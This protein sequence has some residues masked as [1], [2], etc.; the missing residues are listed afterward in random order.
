MNDDRAD[1]GRPTPC[2]RHGPRRR[3]RY[4]R[5]GRPRP[6]RALPRCRD[7]YDRLG[8]VCEACCDYRQTA[9]YYR[10]AINVIRNC[11]PTT[12]IPS[13]RSPSSKGSSTGSNRRRTTPPTE[14]PAG[15]NPAPASPGARRRQARSLLDPPCAPAPSRAGRRREMVRQSHQGMIRNNDPMDLP[16]SVRDTNRQ[17]SNSVIR[18]P[19]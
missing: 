9:D 10:K 2:G 6:A 4:R 7:G 16:R 3:S 15:P 11:T 14:L 17:T 18:K 19:R 5:T 8:M 1:R 13:S 12:T